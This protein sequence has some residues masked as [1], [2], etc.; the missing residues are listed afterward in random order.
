[1][2]L[3]QHQKAS[4]SQFQNLNPPGYPLLRRQVHR[5]NK[6]ISLCNTQLKS[7]HET[8]EVIS[9]TAL[10]TTSQT[11][12]THHTYNYQKS[13]SELN[14]N[15][16]LNVTTS[17]QTVN[18][19]TETKAETTE[20]NPLATT[21]IVLHATI[22]MRPHETI[23]KHQVAIGSENAT[24]HLAITVQKTHGPNIMTGAAI[25]NKIQYQ[26]LLERKTLA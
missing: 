23:G 21:E 10:V 1:M 17:D 25:S 5:Q 18:A 19:T 22:E 16:I 7:Q 12:R 24:H 4:L 6:Q 26:Y 14:A 9:T 15:E 8:H 3:H 11:D 2:L 20:T 13:G